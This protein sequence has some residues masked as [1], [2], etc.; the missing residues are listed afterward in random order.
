[1]PALYKGMANL[2]MTAT[3]TDAVKIKSAMDRDYRAAN[4]QVP[5]ASKA[6]DAQRSYEKRLLKIAAKSALFAPPGGK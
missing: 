5:P 2:L 3:P 1:M 6:W 4:V